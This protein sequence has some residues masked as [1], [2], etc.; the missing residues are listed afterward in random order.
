MKKE[1]NYTKNGEKALKMHLFGYKPKNF[2]TPPAAHRKLICRE[3]KLISKEGGGIKMIKM[4]NISP[5]IFY[6]ISSLKITEISNNF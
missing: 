5:C 2:R 4:H 6:I 1:E 3:K